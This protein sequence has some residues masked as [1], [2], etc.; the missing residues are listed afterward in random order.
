MI[1]WLY[2]LGVAAAC[3]V[4]LLQY[5]GFELLGRHFMIYED[6]AAAAVIFLLLSIFFLIYR[7]K[8]G[9]HEPQT[10]THQLDHGDLKI[11]YDTLEQLSLK[12]ASRVRGISDIKARVHMNEG[13]TMRIAIKFS[14]EA[15]LEIT[16]TTAELQSSVKD[17]VELTTG[18]PVE[19]VTVYVLELAQQTQAQVVKKRVE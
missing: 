12:A 18:I 13:G 19:Q 14:I 8:Q 4:V 9:D 17:F 5:A 16:K 3:V 2:A 10:I 11:S 6:G 7:S 1:L 15:G